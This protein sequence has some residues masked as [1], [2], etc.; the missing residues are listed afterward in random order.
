M[1]FEVH[2]GLFSDSGVES[3]SLCFCVCVFLYNY[4]YN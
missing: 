3:A 4:L 1:I 2:M